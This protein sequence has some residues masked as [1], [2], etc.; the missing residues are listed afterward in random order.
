MVAV[1]KVYRNDGNVNLKEIKWTIKLRMLATYMIE[2]SMFLNSGKLKLLILAEKQRQQKIKDYTDAFAYHLL[3]G[4]FKDNNKV[5]MTFD[6]E[7]YEIVQL[8]LASPL[9]L[10]YKVTYAELNHN[11]KEIGAY[12][13]YV[14]EIERFV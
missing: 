2:N 5:V 6:S 4:K 13:N 10:Q 3:R 14:A 11:L 8:V 1:G 12:V 7:D 9:F